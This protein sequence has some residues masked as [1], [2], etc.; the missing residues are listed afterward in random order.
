MYIDDLKLGLKRWISWKCTLLELERTLAIV[1]NPF[2]LWLR[3]R[4]PEKIAEWL[5]ASFLSG[6]ARTRSQVSWHPV[7][8][9]VSWCPVRS[10][11]SWLLFQGSF[12]YTYWLSVLWGCPGLLTLIKLLC[13]WSHSPHKMALMTGHGT[14]DHTCIISLYSNESPSPSI[15][16]LNGSSLIIQQFI[17]LFNII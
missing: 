17:M 12:H 6:R 10:Q 1:Y 5:W 14:L 9:Q 8:S 7:R 4:S 15:W 16:N 11:V 13:K 3:T 2:A